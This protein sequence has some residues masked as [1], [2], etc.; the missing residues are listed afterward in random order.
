MSVNDKSPVSPLYRSPEEHFHS[1]ST[2]GEEE[3]HKLIK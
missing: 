1:F 2:I 3:L